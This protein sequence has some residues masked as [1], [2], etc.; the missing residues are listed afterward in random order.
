MLFYYLQLLIVVFLSL[1][2]YLLEKFN[3]RFNLYFGILA[4]IY[5]SLVLG[6][7]GLSVG[8]DTFPY[9]RSFM[10]QNM[11]GNDS[12]DISR[13]IYNGLSHVV[14]RYS[15]GSYHIFLLVIGFLTVF[16]VFLSIKLY[17]KR[18]N[19]LS[20][21][22]YLFLCFYLLNF[23][24]AR[25]SLSMS[26]TLLSLVLILRDN[27]KLAFVISVIA[28]GIHSTAIITLVY[29][30]F[31]FLKWNL[32][33]VLILIP[34]I[35]IALLFV[36]MFISIFSNFFSHYQIYFQKE[37]EFVHLSTT[38]IIRCILF[39]LIG[40]V[41]MLVIK[42]TK[43]KI[44]NDFYFLLF[45]NNTGALIYLILSHSL[46]YTRIAQYFTLVNIIFI[47]Y[48]FYELDRCSINKYLKLLFKVIVVG[49]SLALV[50]Y[51]IYINS[52]EIIPYIKYQ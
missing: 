34:I 44:G 38:N 35:G 20:I 30:S 24:I 12:M 22:M 46:L 13:F 47:P 48:L 32:R 36:D 9:Y 51:T 43:R 52:G 17:F 40:L 4:L 50:M 26:V 21:I 23:N 3:K 15:D 33:K 10:L 1:L 31:K 2:F 49:I 11:P 25:Q 18:F 39:T 5:L 29:Y 42:N 6:N 28:I 19:Y 7:R 16:F 45:L 27:S 14:Y 8:T 37:T 41:A